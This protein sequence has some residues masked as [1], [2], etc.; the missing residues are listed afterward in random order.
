M[1]TTTLKAPPLEKNASNRELGA[2]GE[3]LACRYLT[4][5]DYTIV[6]R[7][8]R[9][10]EGEIDIIAHC[11]AEKRLIAVEVKTRRIRGKVPAEEAVSRRKVSRLR[12]L[13]A[14]WL[15]NNQRYEGEVSIDLI[16]VTVLPGGAWYLHHMQDISI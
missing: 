2:W 16:A 13:F 6:E 1:T 14:S 4:A 7:N 15:K 3:E 12:G 10:R 9:V 11:L 5:H 8:Y